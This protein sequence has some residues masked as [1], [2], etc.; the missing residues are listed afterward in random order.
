MCP[1]QVRRHQVGIVEIGQR[2]VRMGRAHIKHR[3]A[4]QF[5]LDRSESLG[6]QREG[7]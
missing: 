3:L 7:V 5:Q 6:R 1:T 2:R 4:E